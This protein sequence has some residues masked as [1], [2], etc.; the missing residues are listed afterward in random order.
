MQCQD[1]S[2][3]EA[4]VHLTQIVDNDVTTRHLCEACAAKKGIESGAALPLGTPGD[5]LST[6]ATGVGAG[7]PG[8]EDALDKDARSLFVDETASEILLRSVVDGGES[9]ISEIKAKQLDGTKFDIQMSANCNRNSDGDI[10]GVVLSLVDIS[11]RKRAETAERESERR[12]VMLESLGAACHHLGQPATILLANLGFLKG[13]VGP[14][15][16]AVKEV[17]DGS[18]E[19]MDRLGRILHRLNAVNEYKTTE[20]L[21]GLTGD[22]ADQSRILD[23]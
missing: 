19:A 14:T 7:L 10:V 4:V 20:Y 12:R 17:I 1:C 2:E 21:Q 9:G 16:P 22:A 13:R 6:M 11:D 3:N 18:L 8:M 15:D 23:I 5:F